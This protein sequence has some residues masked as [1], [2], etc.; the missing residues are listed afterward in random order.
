MPFSIW[1]NDGETIWVNT[2][3]EIVPYYMNNRESIV[4][5]MPLD[6]MTIDV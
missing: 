6:R 1:S 3:N 5:T 4:E 2:G